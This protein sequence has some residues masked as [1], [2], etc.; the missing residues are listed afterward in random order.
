MA[1]ECERWQWRELVASEH[2]PADPGTRLVLFVLALHMSQLGDSCFPS[3]QTVAV[4]SGFSLRSVVT[5]LARAEDDGW[6]KRYTKPRKGGHAYFSHEYVATIPDV[7]IGHLKTPP[8]EG[9]PDWKRTSNPKSK[10]GANSARSAIPSKP[11]PEPLRSPKPSANPAELS[12]ILAEQGA[13]NDG[14]GC[15]PRQNSVQTLHT[16]LSSKLSVNHSMNTPHECAA[17][18]RNTVVG[19]ELKKANE[20]ED[21][22]VRADRIRVM[23][24]KCPDYSDADMA[25]VLRVSIAEVEQARSHG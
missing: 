1:I 20:P 12:A 6:I 14:T 23:L 10:Q 25:K 22:K 4:R 24:T 3:Q 19:A 2:G 8:W 7:L 21:P 17:L 5:H 18:A 9:D 13:N 16:K 15:N 11:L